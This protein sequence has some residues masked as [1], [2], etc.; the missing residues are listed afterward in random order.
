MPVTSLNAPSV[1]WGHAFPVFDGKN[2]C[3]VFLCSLSSRLGAA[4]L[5]GGFVFYSVFL[6]LNL[7]GFGK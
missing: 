5:Q 3:L 7:K 6:G 1:G 2:K 4:N